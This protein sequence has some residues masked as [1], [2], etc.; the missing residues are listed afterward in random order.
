MS[1]NVTK[2]QSIVMEVAATEYDLRSDNAMAYLAAIEGVGIEEQK[3]LF[4]LSLSVHGTMCTRATKKPS[5]RC[6]KEE[7][8][9]KIAGRLDE[10]VS[11][12]SNTAL[13]NNASLEETAG[14]IWDELSLLEG[15]D[16][17]VALALLLQD[18]AV[19]YAQLSGN[20]MVVKPPDVYEAALVG[21]YDKVA[22]F[23]R[24]FTSSGTSVSEIIVA[25]V[26]ILEKIDAHEA[27]VA[28]LIQTTNLIKQRGER[29]KQKEMLSFLGSML[30]PGFMPRSEQPEEEDS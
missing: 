5:S 2:R 30:P 6:M 9:G 11:G 25:L 13:R 27:R 28:F 8:Y 23:Y 15:N 1:P 16:K 20:L 12:W 29:Q 3:A 4:A 7:V 14:V 22:L 18:K 24:V 10:M 17:I 21:H 19:P 26:R